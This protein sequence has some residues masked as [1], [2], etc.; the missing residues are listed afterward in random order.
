MHESQY[1][2]R[3]LAGNG[4]RGPGQGLTVGSYLA[5]T[6]KGAAREWARGYKDALER[7]VDRRVAAGE[8][9][10][11][12][13]AHGRTAYYPRVVLK[14]SACLTTVGLELTWM[15]ARRDIRAFVM[16]APCQ[17]RTAAEHPRTFFRT[18][19]EAEA[20]RE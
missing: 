10:A 12:P 17:L 9:V 20:A 4:R 1:I 16:C 18:R 7:A 2:S 14:C 11:G 15:R 5:Y 13:S 19:K 6:L 8:A 3:Y